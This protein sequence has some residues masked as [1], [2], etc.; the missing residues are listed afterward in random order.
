[1]TVPSTWPPPH[2]DQR[3]ALGH[4]D[5]RGGQPDVADVDVVPFKGMD[6]LGPG[7]EKLPPAIDLEVLF[8]PPELPQQMGGVIERGEI[9]DP[10]R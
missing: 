10:Q 1:M 3:H 9:T 4:A 5:E 8:D 2:T 6:H 7:A